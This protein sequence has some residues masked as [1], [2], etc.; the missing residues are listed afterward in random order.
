MHKLMS[1]IHKFTP[2]F[3]WPEYHAYPSMITCVAMDRF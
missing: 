3:H 1:Q 2:Y